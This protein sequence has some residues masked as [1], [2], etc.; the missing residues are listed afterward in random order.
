ME[1]SELAGLKLYGLDLSYFTGKFEAFVRYKEIPHKRIELSMSL[2]R[3]VAA[4]TGL[5]QMPAVELPDGRWM[6][7][8]SPMID[9]IDANMPG[10]H[11]V[12]EDPY[13][14][15]F[16]RLLE[17]YADEWLWRPALHYRWSFQPDARLMSHRI[18]GEMLHDMPAPFFMRRFFLYRRQLRRY[19]HGDGITA[20]TRHHVESVYSRNLAF[21]E[22]MLQDRLFLLG[23]RPT[24][25]DF[26][27]FA[28]MFRHFGL[29]PTPAR[30]MRDKAP[31]VYEW[32][33][34]M[35]NAKA[36]KVNGELVPARTIPE[37][38]TPVLEDMA[39][40]YF[41]YLNANA[42][43]HKAGEKTFNVMIEGVSYTLPVHRY[44]VWCL[45]QLQAAWHELPETDRVSVQGVLDK[46]GIGSALWQVSNP[47]SGFDPQGNAP[48]YV[49]GQI[50]SGTSR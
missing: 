41:P 29:D 35:W 22:T 47:D 20:K 16:S 15:F 19:V 44:R 40:C 3:K 7:D 23:E 13:Q 4:K 27:F 37:D 26:G 11:V 28:S 18:A 36:S 45:E 48:F 49:P 43:A 38:W 9:W 24:L 30:I 10:P 39:R 6:S 14:R 17:D 12:P 1:I 5:A 32:L 21:L 31:A 2:M 33:G 46:S 34:R 25:A 8:T 42:L 50:W